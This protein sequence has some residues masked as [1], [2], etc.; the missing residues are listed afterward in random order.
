MFAP[1]LEHYLSSRR[2]PG[3]TIRRGATAGAFNGN[4]ASLFPGAFQV[5]QSDRGLTYGGTPL[6]A[7]GNTSTT[8]LTLTGS[9]ASVP[10]PIWWKATNSAAIGSGATFDIFYDGAGII[11]AMS[12]VTPTAGTPVALTGAAT[13]LSTTWSAGNSAN[14]GIWKATCAGLAD[15]SGNGM[16]YT[17]P[18]ASRQPVITSGLNGKC[19]LLFDGVDDYLTSNAGSLF[20]TLYLILVVGRITGSAPSANALVAGGVP[21]ASYSGVIYEF[22]AANQFSQYSSSAANTIPLPGASNQRWAAK[23][24]A[25]TSDSFRIGSSGT[26]TGASS[27]SSVGATRNIA[28]T[29]DPGQFAKAEVFTVI[30]VPATTDYAAFDVA[31]NSPNGYGPGAIAV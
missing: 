30:Y 15:Q 18:T 20:S 1:T 29:A 26:V 3:R 4:F 11:P 7:I 31:I 22:P 8:V 23:F 27:G 13:G 10:V 6:P 25:S 9:L 14:G 16:H 24:T 2:A 19:G 21:F 5:A 17:Q 12:G 28:G